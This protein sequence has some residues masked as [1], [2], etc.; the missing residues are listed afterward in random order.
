MVVSVKL[1]APLVHVPPRHWWSVETFQMLEGHWH[2][3]VITFIIWSNTI[4][5]LSNFHINNKTNVKKKKLL[6][7]S[8]VDFSKDNK[9]ILLFKKTKKNH[10]ILY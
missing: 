3:F 10:N 1:E 9:I 7:D 5:L 2:V 8:Y 6:W 4:M